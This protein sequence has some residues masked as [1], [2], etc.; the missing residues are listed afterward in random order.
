M[1]LFQ[2]GVDVLMVN[3]VACIAELKC[4]AVNES[5][6]G[7][8]D[9]WNWAD[10]QPSKFMLSFYGHLELAFELMDLNQS[11]VIF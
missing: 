3:I 4:L 9:F 11:L 10:H 6:F 1:I 7:I 2:F 8:I 5:T